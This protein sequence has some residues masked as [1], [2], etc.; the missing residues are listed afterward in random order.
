MALRRCLPKLLKVGLPGECRSFP[1]LPVL[2][3]TPMNTQDF[4]CEGFAEI[5]IIAGRLF[6]LAWL[7]AE[8]KE[9]R[10]V[11]TAHSLG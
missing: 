3:N 4:K 9:P 5:W 6:G 7:K 10:W 8:T 1:E 11:G 2:G